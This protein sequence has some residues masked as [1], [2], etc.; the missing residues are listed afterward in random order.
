MTASEKLQK[1]SPIRFQKSIHILQKQDGM[2]SMV[3]LQTLAKFR[4]N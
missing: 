3:Y 1:G 4:K 2:Y